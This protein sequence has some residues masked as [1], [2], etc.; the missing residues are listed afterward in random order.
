MKK[1]LSL[2]LML[3][4]VMTVTTVHAQRLMQTLGRGVV[5]AKNG[6][7]A[8]ITWRRLAQDPEQA[9]WNVYVNGTK[10]NTDPVTNTNMQTAASKL[11]VGSKVTVTVVNGEK[12]SEPSA[13]FTVKNFDYRNLFVS[14]LFDKSPLRAADFNTSYVW[15]IDL[16]GDGEMDYVVNRKSNSNALD[17]YVEGYLSSGEFLWTVKLGPNELS[18]AGQDDMITV[19]DM[20]CDG[21]GDVIIQSSDGTQFWNPE[22]GAWVRAKTAVKSTEEPTHGKPY[23]TCPIAIAI[24]TLNANSPSKAYAL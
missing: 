23:W 13:P 10:I 15:P 9:K 14:I 2:L 7:N 19:A 16:D 4:M 1:K 24:Q 17:C 20:D 6:A 11:P 22:A 12:E 3:L 21:L 18:C 5:V 8:T